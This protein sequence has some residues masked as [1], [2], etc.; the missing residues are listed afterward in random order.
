ME[1]KIMEGDFSITISS[2]KPTVSR[3][4]KFSDA[5]A[6]SFSIQLD[7]DD[8]ATL[9]DLHRKSVE[10]VIELLQRTITRK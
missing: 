2:G 6:I 1:T 3:N 4:F 8:A 10:A 7:R 5:T 9:P